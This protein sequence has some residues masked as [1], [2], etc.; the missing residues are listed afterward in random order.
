LNPNPRLTALPIYVGVG[1]TYYAAMREY[2]LE[3][4]PNT[5]R[6]EFELQFDPAFKLSHVP[7]NMELNNEDGIHFVSEYKLEGNTLRG[8]R[9]M[10]LSQKR[11][12]CSPTDYAKRKPSFD[13]ITKHL[14]AKLLYQ[15]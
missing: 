6:E 5:V 7:K 8:T 3:C 2:A 13:L 4:T 10:V 11:N 1:D 15:Q 12:V 14:K 9:T